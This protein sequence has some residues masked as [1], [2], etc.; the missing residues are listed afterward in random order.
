MR[1]DRRTAL[2]VPRIAALFWVA[3]LLTTAMGESISDYSVRRFDPVLAVTVGFLLFAG[4][5]AVQL[6]VRRYLA[7][8]YWV[9]VAMVAIFG[10]MAADVLHV[11]FSVPYA[12]SSAGFAVLLA[13]VFLAWQRA[14]R[15]LSIHTIDS[16]RRECFYWATVAATFA[17]GTAVGDLTATTLGL[18]YL[19][20]AILFACLIVLPGLA[21]RLLHANAVLCFWCAYVLTRPLGASIADWLGKPRPHGL[22][23]GD[24][25]VGLSCFVLFVALVAYLA[26]TRRDVSA[27]RAD[28]DPE[29]SALSAPATG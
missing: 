11:R 6:W 3:K 21:W 17:L 28:R 13:V 20:A 5:L 7:V 2:K 8:V 29:S 25:A 10:T 14:E 22:G 19:G 15:S 23:Y 4:A 16:T 12:A 9:T 27:P 24:G 1:L 18:G 26:V